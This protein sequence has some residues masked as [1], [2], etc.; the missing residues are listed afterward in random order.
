MSQHNLGGGWQSWG[1]RWKGC[2]GRAW[3]MDIGCPFSRR[4]GLL[5]RRLLLHPGDGCQTASWLPSRLSYAELSVP[6][7]FVSSS[8]DF[9]TLHLSLNTA[10]ASP[11]K[12]HPTSHPTADMR[13][14]WFQTSVMEAISISSCAD[15]QQGTRKGISPLAAS[16][17]EMA[18]AARTMFRGAAGPSSL[19]ARP[20]SPLPSLPLPQPSPASREEPEMDKRRAQ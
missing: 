8:P 5:S 11:H 3:D 1:H 6:A 9:P 10:P 7:R 2:R 12:S 17:R 15:G 14:A 4:A 16:A 19:Q 20:P 18:V 13:K